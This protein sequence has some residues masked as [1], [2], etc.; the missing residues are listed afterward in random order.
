MIG[1]LWR[2]SVERMAHGAGEEARRTYLAEHYHPGLAVE[3][4]G[5]LAAQ[6]RESIAELELEGKQVRYLRATIVPRDES[7]LLVLEAT[8][9]DLV[10]EAYARAGVRFDRISTILEDEAS[11]VAGSPSGTE[12]KEDRL[13]VSI[14]AR[15]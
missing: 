15:S 2:R 9:E 12:A 1:P 8:S 5:R 3:E 7:F 14:R 10:R 4:L 13:K 6:V 11:V